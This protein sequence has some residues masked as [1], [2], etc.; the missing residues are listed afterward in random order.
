MIDK[1]QQEVRE[2]PLKREYQMILQFFCTLWEAFRNHR[3][4]VEV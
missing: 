3:D 1:E 2:G 4:N